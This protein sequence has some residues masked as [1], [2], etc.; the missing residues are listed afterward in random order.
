MS[1]KNAKIG[2]FWRFFNKIIR[3]QFTVWHTANNNKDVF[4]GHGH[5][6]TRVKTTIV[7]V[8]LPWK[9]SALITLNERDHCVLQ[10]FTFE[11]F[12]WL[13]FYSRDPV[14]LYE[15]WNF[16]TFVSRNEFIAGLKKKSER[17]KHFVQ[18]SGSSKKMGQGQALMSIKTFLCLCFIF[19][20]VII[21]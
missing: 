15:F 1:M 6:K 9:S 13:L 3:P 2:M 11:E 19:I 4:R 21:L 17:P 10:R 16:H 14:T 5:T 18:K 8:A 7:D 12:S 20:F